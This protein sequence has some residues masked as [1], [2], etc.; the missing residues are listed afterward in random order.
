MSLERYV[1]R[2]AVIQA[3]VDMCKEEE[4]RTT[5]NSMNT[6]NVRREVDSL[7]ETEI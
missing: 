4:Q 5:L 7:Q 2:N 1:K 6:R 3:L